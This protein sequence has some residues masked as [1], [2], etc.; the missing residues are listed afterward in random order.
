MKLFFMQ[1]P[2][3]A[4]LAQMTLLYAYRSDRPVTSESVSDSCM[5]KPSTSQA[6]KQISRFA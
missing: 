1:H 6:I 3:G 5:A 2:A 4:K